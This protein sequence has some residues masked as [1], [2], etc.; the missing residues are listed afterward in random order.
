MTSHSVGQVPQALGSLSSNVSEVLLFLIFLPLGVPANISQNLLAPGDSYSSPL[1]IP[2]P[3]S[4][5]QVS[6]LSRFCLSAGLAGYI[7]LRCIKLTQ[8]LVTAHKYALLRHVLDHRI[9]LT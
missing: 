4:P 2:S 8:D 9:L 5:G 6:A 7:I 3:C 1:S